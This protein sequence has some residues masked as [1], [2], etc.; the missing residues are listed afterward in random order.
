M[1][2]EGTGANAARDLG[3]AGRSRRRSRSQPQQIF[4]LAEING[5]G[6]IQHIWMTPT[7]TWRFSILRMYWD[8]ETTPS[9]ECPVGDFFA[10]GW[11]RYA[12]ISSLAVCVN[13]GSAF[14]SYWTDA[15]PQVARDHAREHRREGDDPLLP[16]RPTR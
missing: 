1:A 11:G 9:V 10:S 2:T 3:A 6:A 14:N 15:V 7:G 4:T 8:G 12:Q 16:D 13:P 5:P